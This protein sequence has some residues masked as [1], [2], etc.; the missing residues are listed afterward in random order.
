MKT[1]FEQGDKVDFHSIIGGPVTSTGHEIM[2]IVRAPNNFGC[3]IA[4]I[5]GKSSCVALDALSMSTQG[6]EGDE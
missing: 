5:L 1:K 2:S 6:S 3:D 4:W